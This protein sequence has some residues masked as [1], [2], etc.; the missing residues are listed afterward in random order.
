MS[1]QK[2]SSK[3][4]CIS[5]EIRKQKLK[6]YSNLCDYYN[7]GSL[8]SNIMYSILN[9]FTFISIS[10]QMFK[11]RAKYIKDKCKP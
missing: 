5:Q 7:N 9:E 10:I 6:L 2:F 8:E 1:W 4:M 3:Y 11:I